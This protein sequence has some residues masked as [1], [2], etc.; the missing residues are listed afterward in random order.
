MSLF[1]DFKA[2]VKRAT[3]GG[4]LT[5]E[6]TRAAFRLLLSGEAEPTQ[7]AAYATALKVR[8]ETPEEIAA[9]A[10]VM[11]ELALK[12]DAPDGVIDTCGTGGDGLSTFNIS[13]AV[14][15]IV[16]GCGVPV[17]KHGA[18][19]VSSKSGSSD[20][21]AALG[22]N[23]D[24]SPETVAACIRG[25]GVGFLFAP[26]HH[27]A[28]KY[29]A[30]VRSALGVRT[31]F[32]LLGPL[33]NPAGAKRQLVGVYATELVEPLANVLRLLGSE[34]SWVVH[35]ADGL[36]ELTTTTETLVAEA[37]PDRVTSFTVKPED[38]GIKRSDISDLK[39]GTAN[40]NAK[41]IRELLAGATGAYRDVAV[42]NAAAALVIAERAENLPEGAERARNAIDS[43]AAQSSLEKLVALSYGEVT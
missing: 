38:I 28:M 22:V 33:S 29:A 2:V 5:G 17:A 24:A 12:V 43:G 1:P 34:K 40:E 36:D 32:N 7:I 35:G 20:V 10:S 30:P 41:A 13:T 31:I 9:A 26:R 42:L 21:L 18:R 19:A 4:P 23:V 6:E 8:G 37:G 39:G 3:E 11:R 14:A 25:A 15:L 16:A 27:G